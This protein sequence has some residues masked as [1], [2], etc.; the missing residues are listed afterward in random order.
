MYWTSALEGFFNTLCQVGCVCNH[1][2]GVVGF[3]DREIAFLHF[4][5]KS[6]SPAKSSQFLG[7]L[8]S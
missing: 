2:W 5:A 3:G 6:L 8:L 4:P 1:G 7:H